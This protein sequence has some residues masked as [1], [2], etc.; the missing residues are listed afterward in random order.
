MAIGFYC[1]G[2]YSWY[3]ATELEVEVRSHVLITLLDGLWILLSW[4]LLVVSGNELEIEVRSYVLITLLDGHWVL[5]S[6]WLLV[7]L[8]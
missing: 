8:G 6:W 5:L 3:L 2:C 7:V 4:W 1:Y